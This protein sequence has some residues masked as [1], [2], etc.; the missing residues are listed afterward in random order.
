LTHVVGEAAEPG[1][2]EAAMSALFM[3]T[4]VYVAVNGL[5]IACWVLFGEGTTDEAAASFRSLDEARQVGFWP[6]YIIFFWGA[7]LLIHAGATFSY[8][9]SSHKRRK[10]RERKR[11]EAQARIVSAV[12]GTI[13][14]DAALAGITFVDGEKEALRVIVG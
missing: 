7:G 10:A 9:L 11:R 4:V 12:D 13:L 8:R 5:L 6:L 14:A 2:Q 3:H 1:A